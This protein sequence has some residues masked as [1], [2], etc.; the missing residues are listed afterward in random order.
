MCLPCMKRHH[1]AQIERAERENR[2]PLT[3]CP[4][5]RREQIPVDV[6]VILCE[7]VSSITRVKKW[8]RDST[9]NRRLIENQ[10]KRISMLEKQL[11]DT[12]LDLR[13]TQD[14]LE[15]EQEKEKETETLSMQNHQLLNTRSANRRLIKSQGKR[16][17][18]L[19]QQLKD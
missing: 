13:I 4:L 16:I 17:S 2:L 19:E 18:A 1:I 3:N 11:Q 5:C 12:L 6:E 15:K 7:D 9:A 10:R 14:E 8:K